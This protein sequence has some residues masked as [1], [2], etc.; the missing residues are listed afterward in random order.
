L[1]LALAPLLADG[2]AAAAADAKPVN[3]FVELTQPPTARAGAEAP[4]QHRRVLAEQERFL[5]AME[6][7]AVKAT[8]LYRVQRA[9]NGVVLMVTP[10]RIDLLRTLP[11][12][13]SV[14]LLE[15]EQ[16]TGSSQKPSKTEDKR[17][18]RR[19]SS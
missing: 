16:L 7:A 1:L 18:C 9:R 3:V 4:A 17:A 8:I 10:D 2:D 11:G 6:R 12:V 15:P 19:D 13:K 14:Q 5:A